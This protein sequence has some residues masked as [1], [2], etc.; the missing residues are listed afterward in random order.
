M[1]RMSVPH[2]NLI[3]DCP[4][5]SEA[6]PVVVGGI[7]GSGTRVIAQLL[8]SLDFDMGSDLERGRNRMSETATAFIDGSWLPDAATVVLCVAF[9][10]WLWKMEQ[11][12]GRVTR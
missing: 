8:Q 10:F 2:E 11:C 4:M 12:S 3:I 6:A 5:L 1:H 7:G 9:A